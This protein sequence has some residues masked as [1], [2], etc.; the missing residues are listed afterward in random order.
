LFAMEEIVIN[1]I[2]N[3]FDKNITHFEHVFKEEASEYEKDYQERK[4]Q[5]AYDQA[6]S[7]IHQLEFGSNFTSQWENCRRVKQNSLRQQEFD[8]PYVKKH[9]AVKEWTIKD[10]NRTQR[11]IDEAIKNKEFDPT[12]CEVK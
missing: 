10:I 2:F 6:E 12:K 4:E 11:Y 7:N 5:E 1:R 3:M 9:P 8:L